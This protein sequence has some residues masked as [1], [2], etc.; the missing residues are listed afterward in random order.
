M[1]AIV[2]IDPAV[3][4]NLRNLCNLWMVCLKP[5]L[6]YVYPQRVLKFLQFGLIDA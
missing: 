5:R 2:E 3:L 6:L 4:T 1:Y